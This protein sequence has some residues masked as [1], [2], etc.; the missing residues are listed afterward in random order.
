MTLDQEI[1]IW[2]SREVDE[3]GKALKKLV[4]VT[5]SYFNPETDE[6]GVRD[7][8]PI[9]TFMSFYCMACYSDNYDNIHHDRELTTRRVKNVL[10]NYDL[11]G[12]ENVND[13]FVELSNVK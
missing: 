9:S 2:N 1:Q 12:D 6:V 13:A 10:E 3:F 8:T 4:E 7:T 5:D 11:F